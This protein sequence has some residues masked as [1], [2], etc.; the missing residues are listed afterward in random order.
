MKNL[1]K[2]NN[3]GEAAAEAVVPKRCMYP[4][5]NNWHRLLKKLR[6]WR[7]G[8]GKEERKEGN[9]SQ[10]DDGGSG[11]EGEIVFTVVPQWRASL[12]YL[13]ANITF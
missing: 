10:R 3:G 13:S 12:R 8:G 9:K 5:L 6:G 11:G 2:H 1:P 4:C 7:G